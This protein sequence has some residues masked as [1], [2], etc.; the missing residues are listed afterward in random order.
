MLPE[1]QTRPYWCILQTART[2]QHSFEEVNKSLAMVRKTNPN[3]IT[4]GFQP[5][6]NRLGADVTQI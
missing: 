5:S 4:R 2:R 1:F 3:L 6:Q